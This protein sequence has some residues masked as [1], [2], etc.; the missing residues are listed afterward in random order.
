MKF[1]RNIEKV[2]V[3]YSKHPYTHHLDFT[4][5]ISLYLLYYV[6]IHFFWRREWQSTPIFL[7]GESPWTEE[8]G[9]LQSMRLQR[10]GHD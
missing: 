7:P 2:K 3:F 10:V 4:R 8:T 9:R 1:F 5:N 6:T